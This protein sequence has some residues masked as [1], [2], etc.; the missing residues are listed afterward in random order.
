M[1][2][3]RQFRLELARLLQNRLTWLA[4]LL[5]ALSPIAGLT[6]YRPLYSSGES[7]YV[8]TMQ[9]MYLA[10]P[11]LAGS[12]LGAAIFAILTVWSM[13]RLRR[14]GMEALAH[15]VVSP[16]TAALTRLGALL[17][18]SILAQAAVTLAWLPYS[19]FKLGAVFDLESYLLI[20]LIFMYGA[21]PL[22]ILFASA[23][24]QFT[25]RAELSLALF[26]AFA[27]LSLTVWADQ[28]Q[29]C[30]LNPCVFGVS[31]DFSNYRILCS[32]AYMRLTWL[33]ALAGLWGV[34]Y[35][36]VR[37]YGKGL[38]GSLS[39]NIRRVYRPFLAAL[40]LLSGSLLYVYQPFVDHSAAEFDF[41]YLFPS[42]YLETVTCSSRRADVH[43][44]PKT[45][46]VSGRAVFQ[47]QNTSGA[48]QTVQF[49][50]DPGYQILS[51]QA[52]G[53]D[54]PFSVDEYQAM[55]E[56]RFDVTIPAGREIELAIGY[57]GFPQEWN[58]SAAA[59]G[60]LEISNVYMQ[61]ENDVL[62]PSPYNIWYQG[63]TLPAVMDLTLPGHMTPIL[64]GAG[65]T[66]LLRENG[67]GTKTWRMTDE[68]YHM[69][70]Y[71]GDYIRE[72]IPVESAGITVNF[73]YSRKHQPIMEAMNA[74][75]AIRQTIAYCTEHIG[76]LSFYGDGTFNLIE[77]RI[78]GGGYA[79]DGASLANEQDFTVQN[80]S[81]GAKGGSSAQ[82]TIHELVHQWWGLDN[83]FDPMDMESVWS[84][85][86]LT[87]YTT[88][89]IVK[90]LY[91]EEAARAAYIDQWQ[92]AVDG[93]Y[94]DFYVRHPEY[95]S[96]LPEQ[97]QLD[98]ANSLRGMRQYNEMPL[99]ILKAEELV[100][101]EEAMDE[102]LSSLFRREQNPEYPYLTYQEFLDAC[103]L[104]EEDLNLA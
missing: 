37:R 80:L 5:T 30:W 72:E 22:A 71:A 1:N 8:T 96:A 18:V 99:K 82:V 46:C 83:M 36:C 64:F 35:L 65:S 85:E 91:G 23:A 33:L 98:I 25:R 48:E 43:P 24:Y 20:H 74:S 6:V 75:E 50:I 89:R 44:D 94:K 14:D 86:G 90:E 54:V 12:I 39:R 41:A 29:L 27:V 32:V 73:Y 52:N 51:V 62:S 92:A 16:M 69:I 10:N 88:Y 53:A 102:I 40:L 13:D 11:A 58:N 47:L 21:I 60:R 79:G 70:V 81:D 100:G 26:A 2:I 84:S 17:C 49:F 42:E 95:L 28:W 67:D 77:S 38:I 45:G 3:L 55:H 93:Y 9:G 57:G 4:I 78:S 61:L 104:T 63:D 97:Y 87:C 59:Q 7:G 101:G 76:S 56:K 19:I 31:D 66:E 103:H 68:G 34:S 15:A